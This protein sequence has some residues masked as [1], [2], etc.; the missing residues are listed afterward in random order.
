MTMIVTVSNRQTSTVRYFS[1]SCSKC[2]KNSLF[3]GELFHKNIP[4]FNAFMM[5]GNNHNDGH[6]QLLRTFLVQKQLQKQQTNVHHLRFQHCGILYSLCY[7]AT[8][9]VKQ[10]L[11]HMWLLCMPVNEI[12]CPYGDIN[13]C[14]SGA[15][16]NII[17]PTTKAINV[18][19][20]Y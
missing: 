13:S 11:S 6:L 4:L 3:F 17:E 12:L 8:T 15:R 20:K 10:K 9:A 14:L 5:P 18:L 19:W 7:S 1:F 16:S 2:I